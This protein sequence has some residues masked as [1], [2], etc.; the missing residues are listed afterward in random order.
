MEEHSDD[1][2]QVGIGPIPSGHGFT[3]PPFMFP[4]ATLQLWVPKV[5]LLLINSKPLSLRRTS[6]SVL[7]NSR[8]IPVNISHGEVGLIQE[9]AEADKKPW[10]SHLRSLLGGWALW[11]FVIEWLFLPR[12]PSPLP[13][14]SAWLR[15]RYGRS[16]ALFSF[17]SYRK[18]KGQARVT[19]EVLC[20][21]Y[22]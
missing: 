1:E 14:P 20:S 15:P 9:E 3:L 4:H 2:Q 21:P 13:E 8:T 5:S 12:L 6:N 16:L 11:L 10:W 7:Q 17:L 19:Q 22:Q 18:P